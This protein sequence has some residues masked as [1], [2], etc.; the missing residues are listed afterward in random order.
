MDCLL[1]FHAFFLL[2]WSLSFAVKLHQKDS[3]PSYAA[4][5]CLW[6]ISAPSWILLHNLWSFVHHS[7]CDSSS[8]WPCRRMTF[9]WHQNMYCCRA[10]VGCQRGMETRAGLT[11]SLPCST[12]CGT[13]QATIDTGCDPALLCWSSSRLQPL[14]KITLLNSQEFGH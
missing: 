10:T 14:Q 5:R 7:A 12:P 2:L 4:G 8:G 9:S 11:F 1:L 3:S 13:G 6:R